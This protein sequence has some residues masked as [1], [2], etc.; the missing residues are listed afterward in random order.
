M[1]IVPEF[2]STEE[3]KD[4]IKWIPV[5]SVTYIALPTV[6]ILKSKRLSIR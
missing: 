4:E 6:K 5:N 2:I 1:K 3:W